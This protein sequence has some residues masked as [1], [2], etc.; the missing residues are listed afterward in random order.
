[1]AASSLSMYVSS[2]Q[3]FTQRGRPGAT[4]TYLAREKVNDYKGAIAD[5]AALN[6]RLAVLS[7][8]AAIELAEALTRNT[9]DAI[10]RHMPPAGWRPRET[11]G[12]A[13]EFSKGRLAAA[14]GQYEPELMR[15]TVGDDDKVPV[16]R[17][18]EIWAQRN[19]VAGTGKINEGRDIGEESEIRYGAITEI[20]RVKGNVWTAEVGT[21]LPYAGLANDGGSMYVYP[22]GN[23]AAKPVKAHWEGVHFIEEGI[24]KTEG[25]VENI[26]EGSISQ[27][28]FGQA[29]RRRVRNPGRRRRG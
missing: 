7:R 20:K 28:F 18:H 27:A 13:F 24:S 22:Y 23:R 1:M 2:G 8:D 12:E 5:L 9:K 3:T 21:F 4:G 16:E 19:G 25:E 26:V 10:K 6:T 15:G 14:W 17:K 11:T 29:E